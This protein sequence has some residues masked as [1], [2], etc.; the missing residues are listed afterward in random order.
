[1]KVDDSGWK[2]MKVDKMDESRWKWMTVIKDDESGKLFSKSSL[3]IS[4]LLPKRDPAGEYI[5]H[6]LPSLPGNFEHMLELWWIFF[7]L[8]FDYV[9]TR[10]L[11]ARCAGLNSKIQKIILTAPNF[12]PWPQTFLPTP[13][14][15]LGSNSHIRW[16]CVGVRRGNKW[17]DGQGIFRS[18]R[19]GLELDSWEECGHVYP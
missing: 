12:P 3:S 14:S 16:V 2:W 9:Q 13:I 4:I 1:M 8:K 11:G 17:R 6:L 19:V 15:G 7:T 5:V 10:N 18:T